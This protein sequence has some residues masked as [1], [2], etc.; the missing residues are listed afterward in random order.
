MTAFAGGLP[1]RHLSARALLPLLAAALLCFFALLRSSGGPAPAL[2]AAAP[3]AA[4]AAPQLPFCTALGDLFSGAWETLR[5]SPNGALQLGRWQ[6]APPPRG[7]CAGA[8]PSPLGLAPLRRG[9][10]LVLVGDSVTR[11]LFLDIAME[12]FR[13]HLLAW[14]GARCLPGEVLALSPACAALQE[15]ACR[16]KRH[17]SLTLAEEGGA[18]L[19]FV[20]A[21]YAEQLHLELRA[22]LASPRVDG[23]AVSLGFWDAE[24]G[25]KGLAH[26]CAWMLGFIQ[27]ELQRARA[28][29]AVFW[30][31]PATEPRGGNHKR[32]PAPVMEAANGCSRDAFGAAAFANTSALMGLPPG[33]FSELLAPEGADPRL[34]G[35]LLTEDGYHPVL[36]VRAVLRSALLLHFYAA[37]GEPAD[38]YK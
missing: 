34:G 10:Q 23:V 6:P 30:A 14:D 13:C 4:F 25:E 20:W 2:G 24:G 22:L 5:P 36:K 11:Y 3:L 9:R 33:V 37:W 15:F 8:P 28:G 26:H 17:E 18:T 31:P 29:R 35:A 21:P 7:G 1:A 19:R 27:G 12:L 38:A 16:G 32:I